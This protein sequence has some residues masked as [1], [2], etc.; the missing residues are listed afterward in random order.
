MLVQADAQPSAMMTMLISWESGVEL[1][2][3]PSLIIIHRFGLFRQPPSL[4]IHH[5]GR[6]ASIEYSTG[7]NRAECGTESLTVGRLGNS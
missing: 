3:P 4:L 7:G 2:F 1:R 6:L 5:V